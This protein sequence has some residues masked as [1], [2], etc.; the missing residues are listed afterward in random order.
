MD[1]AYKII[2][3]FSPLLSIDVV[4]P[5]RE[6]SFI[7]SRFVLFCQYTLSPAWV[8]IVKHERETA[9]FLFLFFFSF[10]VTTDY[11][12]YRPIPILLIQRAGE[13]GSKVSVGRC[14]ITVPCC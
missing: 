2:L 8:V 11:Y 7:H 3:F 4:H 5:P 10:Y 13:N 12:Y 14:V 6:H 9:F 1:G